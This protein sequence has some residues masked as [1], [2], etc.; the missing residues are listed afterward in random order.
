[1]TPTW[2]KTY[3]FSNFFFSNGHPLGDPPH[4]TTRKVLFRFTFS[5]PTYSL[6]SVNLMRIARFKVCR[7]GGINKAIFNCLP[8]LAL[9]ARAVFYCFALNAN[10]P[11]PTTERLQNFKNIPTWNTSRFISVARPLK[12]CWVFWKKAFNKPPN[13]GDS[14]YKKEAFFYWHPHW[15]GVRTPLSTQKFKFSV[16]YI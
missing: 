3:S 13:F 12:C 8:A 11:T 9:L 14:K 2:P 6:P 1:M 4:K 10:N 16:E 5:P 15:N 7:Q